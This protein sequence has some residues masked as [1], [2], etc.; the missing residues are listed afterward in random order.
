VLDEV[1]ELFPDPV[2]HIGGDEV[3]KHNW[4]ACP[5]CK[6]RMEEVGAKTPEELQGW[7]NGYFAK[8]LAKKGKRP[9]WWGEIPEAPMPKE[10][11]V[12][13]WL[14]PECGVAAAQRGH[15]VVMCPH[16]SLYL[17]Y[18]PCLSFDY[19]IYPWFTEKLPVEK[20]YEYD[21]LEGIPEK[22]HRFVLGGQGCCW[23]EYTCTEYDLDWKTWTRAAALSEV[24]WTYPAKRDQKEF[25][26][27]LRHHVLRLRNAGVNCSAVEP[28]K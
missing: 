7:M 6:K 17:D 8:Y 15:E 3:K 27:R 5:K 16:K 23:T 9:I 18:T 10:L 25:L 19:C 13:S 4:V 21:P 12:M 20:V 26:P 24:F 22:F 28:S 14:G 2:I 1:C 11:A